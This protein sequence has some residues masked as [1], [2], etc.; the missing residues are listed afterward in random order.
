MFDYN[1]EVIELLNSNGITWGFGGSCLLN[2]LGVEVTPR[3]LDIVIRLADIERAVNV[4][5]ANG[6][7]L[8][9]ERISNNVYLT[10]KFFTLAYNDTEIDF[11]ADAGI[12]RDEQICRLEFEKAGPWAYVDHMGT[13]LF[14]T[15]PYD[16]LDYYALMEGREHRVAQIK[17]L[18]VDM[19]GAPDKY[20]Q[21]KRTE[22]S[23]LKL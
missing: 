20:R 10:K 6:A 15:S 18:L 9:E 21:I 11:M 4:L 3:D 5:V 12:K 1:K 14:L 17:D 8:L 13:R 19:S 16:W 23:V 22:M 2:I 7:V